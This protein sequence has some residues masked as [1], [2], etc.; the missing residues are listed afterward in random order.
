M[1]EPLAKHCPF[2]E[3]QGLPIL[4]LRPAVARR[5]LEGLGPAALDL[6]TTLGSG[7]VDIAL[8]ADSAK[9]TGRLLR[10]G[11]LYTFNE[12]RGEWTAYLVTGY[13]Y[14]YEFDVE[15][16]TPPDADRI[17]FSCFRTGEEYIAR[18]I[19][20]PDAANAGAVW[21]GFSDTAWTP[22]VLEEHRNEAH[23]QRHMTRV[24][25]GQWVSGKT[26]QP[27]TAPFDQLTRVVNEFAAPTTDNPHGGQVIGETR[28][29]DKQS[30]E[31]K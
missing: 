8:P 7:L 20:I 30:G 17:E 5:D 27:N 10:P 6:P 4:P 21:L 25:V 18:C 29:M 2:C 14:L 24:D 31:L 9:Y 26:N 28:V 15:D 22:A 13:G 3:K 19:T 1:T 16:I 12:L 11:Y 23:R